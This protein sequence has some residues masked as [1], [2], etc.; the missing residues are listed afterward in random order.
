VGFPLG[1]LFTV[2][3]LCLD[4]WL[5]DRLLNLHIRP[6]Q[7]SFLTFLI[8]LVLVLSI[9]LLILFVYQVV[10][11]LILR[12]HLDRNGVTI[13]SGGSAWI[14][15][16]RDIQRI[17][18]GSELGP[19]V[20][21]RSGVRWPGHQRGEG[22]VPG[23]GRTLFYASTSLEEQLLLV[24]PG[25]A[26]GISP[27]D[28]EGFSQA[29]S[30]RKK[31]GPNRLL[32]EERRSSGWL[33]WPLWNDRTAGG[34]LGGALFINL[35]L[36]GYICA[37]FPG[38]DQQLPLHFNTLGQADR[39]ATK[40]ELFSLPIIGLIIIVTNLVLGLLL[41]KRERAGAYMLWGAAA[42]VQALFW[43]AALSILP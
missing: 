33:A 8:A 9:P 29:F 24:T 35:S 12:Y 41:C 32:P 40:M 42:V 26:I 36:F 1:I 3:L 17:V 7:I 18:P 23:I 6:Q 30:S 11:S 22:V 28:P 31:L 25:M 34:L 13:H 15:P 21:N 2:V 20:D 37:R 16:I 5:L 27:R 14:I 39:I 43:L 38:L 10:S 4:A 19:S